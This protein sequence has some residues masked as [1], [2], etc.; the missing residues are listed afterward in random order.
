MITSEF[1]FTTTGAERS[2]ETPNY[3]YELP[4]EDL[5]AAITQWRPMFTVSNIGNGPQPALPG[6]WLILLEYPFDSGQWIKV[7][8]FHGQQFT[9]ADE[10][11]QSCAILLA[12]AGGYGVYTYVPDPDNGI[13]FG[14][15]W[16]GDDV[17]GATWD[18]VIGFHGRDV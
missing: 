9:M 8:S 4:R 17:P 14:V 5:P 18:I 16:N 15:R 3:I 12:N 7:A 11:T 13:R 2:A 10:N 6:E 1:A